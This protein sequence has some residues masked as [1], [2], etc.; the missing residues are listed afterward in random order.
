MKLISP[1]NFSAKI[2]MKL[3]LLFCI[4]IL[5]I[6]L[7]CCKDLDLDRKNFRLI[8]PTNSLGFVKPGTRNTGG[9]TMS[10]TIRKSAN[11]TEETG[12]LT[13]WQITKAARNFDSNYFYRRPIIAAMLILTFCSM[14]MILS[15]PCILYIFI[16]KK[17]ISDEQ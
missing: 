2:K 12:P 8:T 5:N 15:L 1:I 7:N 13:L 9:L 6:E 17:H 3:L 16:L 4:F 10:Q 11:T 14:V